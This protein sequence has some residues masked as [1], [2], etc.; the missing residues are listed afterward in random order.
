MTKSSRAEPEAAP[1]RA[2]RLSVVAT[3]IGNLDDITLRALATLRSV[4]AIVAEDTRHTHKLCARHGIGRRLVSFHAHSPDAAV[5][6]LVADLVGGAHLAL[7]TDAGTPL[8]SDP[9]ARLVNA[10][11]RAGIRVEPI[12]GPSALTAALTVAAIDADQFRFVGF[13]PRSG[14]R[15]RAAIA[16]IVA[17]EAATVLYEAPTRIAATLAD[18]AR[19]AGD[20]RR[21][22]VCRELT[23]LHEEVARGTLG[24]LREQFREGARGE[25]TLVI[26]GG[27]PG[28]AAAEPAPP[29]LDDAALDACIATWLAEGASPRDVAR[30]LSTDHAL[31]H[32]DAYQRV[33][34]VRNRE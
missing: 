1:P 29:T 27:E 28:S 31:P 18:L 6:R 24:E 22:S 10:A 3:P 21:A 34:A 7:V 12:P 17:D 11:V 33:L 26:A 16:R 2:G 4:D 25:I 30:R 32:R 19:A 14:E 23:K 20:D 9:G 5:E 13:L 8:V 15:R